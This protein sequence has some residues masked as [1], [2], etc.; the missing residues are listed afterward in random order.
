MK[1]TESTENYLK[2]IFK[3]QTVD[4][5][6]STTD[7][8]DYM[9]VRAAS[10]TG[11]LKK[12]ARKKLVS[13]QPYKGVTL[14]HIG[15]KLALKTLRTHRLIELFLVEHLG[16][17][18]EEVHGEAEKWEHVISGK[19]E[20]RIDKLLGYPLHDPHG[21]P[22]PSANGELKIKD[23]VRLDRVQEGESGTIEE[24]PDEDPEFLAYL[25]E[26]DIIPGNKIK[27]LEKSVV[28]KT[29]KI[30]ITSKKHTIGLKAAEK[31]RVHQ[32]KDKGR[33]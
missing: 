24:V 19:I 21:S 6:V 23:T 11:M 29:L 3:L 22:I 2:S 9:G 7:L 16:L 4:K 10:V 14:T 27:V 20:E 12:L 18:W 33:K 8:A 26:N 13:Y 25:G 15:R 1:N 31:I 32:P 30:Q 5:K 28:G 17:S